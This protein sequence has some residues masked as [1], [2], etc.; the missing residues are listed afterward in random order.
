MFRWVLGTLAGLN[1]LGEAGIPQESDEA[2]KG[3]SLDITTPDDEASLHRM[4]KD[5]LDPNA[6]AVDS[7]F[8]PLNPPKLSSKTNNMEPGEMAQAVRRMTEE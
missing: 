2:D 6:P 3:V 5:S 1:R 8:A 7:G 4:L